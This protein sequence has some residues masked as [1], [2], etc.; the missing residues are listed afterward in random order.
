MFLDWNG[1]LACL[2][3]AF[4]GW[5]GSLMREGYMYGMYGSFECS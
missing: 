3:E 1:M 2:Q 4:N 5:D